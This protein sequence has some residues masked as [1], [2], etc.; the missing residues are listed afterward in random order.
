MRVATSSSSRAALS[1]VFAAR[2]KRRRAT[3]R[4]IS[5]DGLFNRSGHRE[6]APVAHRRP[7]DQQADWRAARRVTGQRNAAT[8]EEIDQAAVAVDA[9]VPAEIL[10]VAAARVRDGRR[11]ARHGGHHHGVERRAERPDLAHVLRAQPAE[12]EV[13]GR[14]EILAQQH[15]LGDARVVL[16][17]PLEPGSMQ[18]IRLG[19]GVPAVAEVFALAVES[20]P[21]P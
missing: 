14:E 9:V 10:L 7:E 13:I 21:G 6:D 15:P 18:V 1:Y 20:G 12:L 16:S 8:I 4:S 19:A 17:D 2:S 5:G 3:L 11:D